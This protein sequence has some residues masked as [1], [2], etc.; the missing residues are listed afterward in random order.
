MVK[1]DDMEEDDLALEEVERRK[2]PR[3]FFHGMTAAVLE[4][5]YAGRTFDVV[6]AS[7]KGLFLSVESPDGI[8]LGTRFVLEVTYK[9]KAFRGTLEVVRKEI[10]PR[11]GVAG[12]FSPLDQASQDTLDALIAVAAAVP[13]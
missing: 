11:R 12:R 7:R 3:G 13:D 9:G 6:E 5:P 2:E 10:Q 1:H 8:P 4:G